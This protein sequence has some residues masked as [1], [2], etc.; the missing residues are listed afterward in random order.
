MITFLKNYGPHPNHKIIQHGLMP[1]ENFS[2]TRINLNTH[3]E[4]AILFWGRVEEY[5]G[6]DIF[7]NFSG[8]Y[9][10]E[11]YGK[12]SP[13]L[14]N[15]K[16]KLS[17][18][19]NILINDKYLSLDDLKQMLSR[20]VIFILPYKDASQSG[21]LYTLLAYSK[22]FVSSNVGENNSFLIKHGLDQLIFDRNDPE[23]L[24]KAIKYAFEEYNEIKSKL[25]EI[26]NE[27]QWSQIMDKKKIYELYNL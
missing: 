26:K 19:N 11:I 6:V 21:I 17:K 2:D 8:S 1:I 25:F 3:L 7:A 4:K 10:L 23:S 14:E 22:I 27:Y 20:D 13:D 9:P 12:W 5:K 15:L 24:S 16:K 18:I